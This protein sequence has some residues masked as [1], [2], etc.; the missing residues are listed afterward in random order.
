MADDQETN[1]SELPIVCPHCGNHGEPDGPWRENGWAPFK[2]VEEVVRSWVFDA[3]ITESGS[4]AL[5][6][7]SGSDDV[8]WESGANLRFECMQCFGQFPIP[9]DADVDFDVL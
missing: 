6:A 8:D 1:W 2:L 5:L 9:E 4:L 3:K 7:D